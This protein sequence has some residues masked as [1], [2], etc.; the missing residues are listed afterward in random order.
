MQQARNHIV[1]A[2]ET[3]LKMAIHHNV[4]LGAA[5][6]ATKRMLIQMDILHRGS[7]TTKVPRMC[8]QQMMAITTAN[9]PTMREMPTT[10]VKIT[11]AKKSN[12]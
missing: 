8:E 7:L 10:M 2:E 9:N 6:D 1:L 12:Q 5:M 11:M 4:E 3:T